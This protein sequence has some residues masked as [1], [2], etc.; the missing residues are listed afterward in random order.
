MTDERHAEDRRK[1]DDPG[2][3][4]LLSGNTTEG[5]RVR[6]APAFCEARWGTA[7]IG[8]MISYFRPDLLA[9]PAPPAGEPLQFPPGEHR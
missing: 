3:G 8:P 2:A 5:E 6:V 4:S 7:V 9:G 1:R